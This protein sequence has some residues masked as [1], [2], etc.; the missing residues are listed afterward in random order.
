MRLVDSYRGKS[1]LGTWLFRIATSAGLGHL[2]RR[3]DRTVEVRSDEMLADAGGAVLDVVDRVDLERALTELPIDCRAAFV[4][5]DVEGFGYQEVASLLG[6]TPAASRSHLHRARLQLRQR[7]ARRE[8][9]AGRGR[10]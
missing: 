10:T 6:F 9:D 1:S 7:L 4:L 8:V 2:R 3:P 5:H